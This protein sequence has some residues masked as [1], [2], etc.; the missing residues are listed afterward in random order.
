M[1]VNAWSIK[2]NV[3]E[4]TL[5]STGVENSCLT[6]KALRPRQTLGFRFIGGDPRTI[7]SSP[8]ARQRPRISNVEF[9]QRRSFS[10]SYNQ[11]LKKGTAPRRECGQRW[12]A[13]LN[14]LYGS[15]Q[16]VVPPM[17]VRAPLVA[18]NCGAHNTSVP[19]RFPVMLLPGPNSAN[20]RSWTLTPLPPFPVT[21]L[22][23]E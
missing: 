5:P 11:L 10:F 14:D 16:L 18:E 21:V 1:S 13:K 9:S 6:S 7:P 22:R 19:P 17:L 12:H 23:P 4:N 2:G 3:K 20:E 15:V 8:S